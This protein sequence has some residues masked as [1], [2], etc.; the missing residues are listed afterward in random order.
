MIAAWPRRMYG[1]CGIE[2]ARRM[3]RTPTNAA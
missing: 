1:H 2:E 3:A